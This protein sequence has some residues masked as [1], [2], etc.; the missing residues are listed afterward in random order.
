MRKSRRGWAETQKATTSRSWCPRAAGRSAATGA[1]ERGLCEFR[2]F[3]RLG[4]SRALLETY[5]VPEHHAR[6][7]GA[8]VGGLCVGGGRKRGK[9]RERELRKKRERE[10]ERKEK[11]GERKEGKRVTFFSESPLTSPLLTVDRDWVCCS[12][13][14]AGHRHVQC[15]DL[16]GPPVSSHPKTVLCD[17]VHSL[18]TASD[19]AKR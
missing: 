4:L 13:S 1:C 11:R 2:V 18:G 8:G 3:L 19:D 14:K 9:E 17:T 15:F 12:L 6:A 16:E 10:K 5:V 7:K